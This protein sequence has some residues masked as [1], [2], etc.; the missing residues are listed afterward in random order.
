M[1]QYLRQHLDTE[2]SME[3]EYATQL[4]TLLLL[5]ILIL[6]M[7]DSSVSPSVSQSVG[8]EVTGKDLHSTDII[9]MP[10]HIS[11]AGITS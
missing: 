8:A 4:Y 1:I 3:G 7:Q 5:T 10:F 2:E 6:F 11:Y 9:S